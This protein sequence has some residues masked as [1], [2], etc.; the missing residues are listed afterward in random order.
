MNDE[1]FLDERVEVLAKY[2]S[3]LN[4][5]VPIKF[6]RASGREVIV[7]EIGL[8]HPTVQGRRTVHVFDV[9]DGAAD[10]RLEFD[11]ERL[12]WRLTREGDRT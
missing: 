9:T 11:S 12:T 3:G 6:R 2:G 10:Y 7:A 5:C 4:P 8:R 1:L